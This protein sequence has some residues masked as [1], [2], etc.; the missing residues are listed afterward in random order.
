VI[1][2]PTLLNLAFSNLID[3]AISF[4]KPNVPLHVEI[5]ARR[6]FVYAV[7]CVRDN[8]IGIEP[9]YSEK[10]FEVFQ[11]LNPDHV[12]PGTGIGLANVKKSIQT[13]GG[14]IRVESSPGLGS[15]FC[16]QLK[17]AYA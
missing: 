1:G 14:R 17:R 2:E 4:R 9:A 10:I 11:R 6:E 15:T 12:S 3:N 16:V 8:G 13:L 7:I 5:T